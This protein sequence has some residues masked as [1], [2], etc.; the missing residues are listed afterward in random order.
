VKS[1]QPALDR[2]P[3]NVIPTSIKVGATAVTA[4]A[5]FCNLALLC[6]A[7]SPMGLGSDGACAGALVL[8]GICCIAAW[9]HLPKAGTAERDG[10]TAHAKTCQSDDAA[11][12]RFAFMCHEMRTPL[13]AVIGFSTLALQD[14]LAPKPREHVQRA[15][16][17]GQH[18]LH[19]VNNTLDVAKLK[20]GHLQL[21]RSSFELQSVLHK[22]L[23][24]VGDSARKK[25]LPLSLDVDPGVP[26]HLVGDRLR[27]TQ[28]LLN[29]VD[30]A[31]KFTHRGVV[32]IGVT[33]A[34]Q[35]PDR[36]VLRFAVRDTGIGL[37]DDQA[38]RIFAPFEQ[39]GSATAGL[40]GGT[41]LGLSIVQHLVH[42]MGGKVTVDSQAGLGSEFSFTATFERIETQETRSSAQATVHM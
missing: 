26:T 19:L 20:A 15:Q 1:H 18:L 23:A 12:E 4:T 2:A 17:A 5:C 30:N 7:C 21:D 11:A 33:L 41:G 16:E 13:N 8:G 24:L 39:A 10:S 36:T 28:V 40:Y 14:D 35:S 6:I 9:W 38:T 34:C 3:V 42:C 31:V 29:L 32:E 22:V 25:D 27:L 37:T